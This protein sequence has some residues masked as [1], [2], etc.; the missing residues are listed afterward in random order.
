MFNKNVLYPTPTKALRLGVALMM[1]V[2]GLMQSVLPV[3]AAQITTITGVAS[4]STLSTAQTTYTFTFTPTTALV[5]GEKIRLTFPS[6]YTTSF[7]GLTDADVSVSGTNITSTV[8]TFNTTQN[9]ITS[10]LTTSG[11]VSTAITVTIGD[12]AGALND[13]TNPSAAGTYGVGVDTFSATD[14]L[15]DQGIATVSIA[16]T[17]SVTAVVTEALIMTLSNTAISL[18]VDPSVN[19][20]QDKS[21]S[22]A[23]TV[24]SNAANGYTISSLLDNGDGSNKNRLKNATAGTYIN[25]YSDGVTTDDYFG[26]KAQNDTLSTSNAENGFAATA[27]SMFTD[28]ATTVLGHTAPINS[29]THHINYDLNVDYLVPA[30]QYTGTITYTVAGSF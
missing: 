5:N 14:V 3:S 9:S 20:G 2:G 27:T 8:E 24:S 12:T 22:T 18:N 4:P 23:I 19:N 21:Q 15:I 13:L 29:K 11:T 25:A 7:A 16:N 30:G 1:V 17:V 6:Q 28:V 10:T 26:Y